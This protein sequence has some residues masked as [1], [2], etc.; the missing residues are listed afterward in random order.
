MFLSLKKQS[1]ENFIILTY[2]ALGL[3]VFAF[4]QVYAAYLYLI[5]EKSSV[6]T[7]LDLYPN[8][9]FDLYRNSD[10][11][12]IHTMIDDI[13][14]RKGSFKNWHITP[15]PY[16]FPDYLV[17]FVGT[18]FTKRIFWQGVISGAV[19]FLLFSWIIQRLFK[20]MGCRYPN[21]KI[22][23]LHALIA[24]SILSSKQEIYGFLWLLGFH[25]GAFLCQLWAVYLGLMLWWNLRQES[26]SDLKVCFVKNKLLILQ[27]CGLTFLMALSDKLF[28][29]QWTMP[30]IL[31]MC[32]WNRH[33]VRM[34]MFYVVYIILL[35][36]S[37]VLGLN[38]PFDA[39]FNRSTNAMAHQKPI[40]FVTT[41]E[42]VSTWMN[43]LS[44][45]KKLFVDIFW[46]SPWIIAIYTVFLAYVLFGVFKSFNKA[47]LEFREYKKIFIERFFL[48]SF[49]LNVL[50]I[51]ANTKLILRAKY[52]IPIFYWPFIWLV[53]LIPDGYFESGRRNYINFHS[54]MAVLYLVIAL[55]FLPLYPQLD[56]Q[57]SIYP[58][59]V[60]CIDRLAKKFD[61]KNGVAE[62]WSAKSLQFLS[63]ANLV[64]A[65][66]RHNGEPY[67]WITSK[68]YYKEEYD[69][70]V[71]NQQ[72]EHENVWINDL[73]WTAMGR[74][75]HAHYCAPYMVLI[76]D[77]QDKLHFDM[78]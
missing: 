78:P 42:S 1:F 37:A 65:Q 17:A 62:Y 25:F 32:L 57:A 21:K 63:R 67:L 61:L 29:L 28:L 77:T 50:L 45:F 22:I 74:I 72:D 76:F 11:V 14:Y 71:F 64:F 40:F 69:F 73:R 35:S 39:F 15:A 46:T 6:Y 52:L 20:K 16:F 19:Q 58:P 56:A 53:F 7:N 10:A 13:F 34:P 68:D 70:L 30:Y 43:N 60:A 47:N 24:L 4:F 26:C 44:I 9:G 23:L 48:L 41:Q 18:I 66:I 31:M 38:I 12:F 3:G 59:S 2:F 8:L 55:K 33:I 75:Y 5:P 27:L 54:T 36:G 51:S 49:F